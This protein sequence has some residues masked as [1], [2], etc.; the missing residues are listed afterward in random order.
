MV[1]VHYWLLN[2]SKFPL[3]STSEFDYYRQ[4]LEQKG[5]HDRGACARLQAATNSEVTSQL[6]TIFREHHVREASY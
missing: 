4:F 3:G 6:T 1:N 2:V 5:T